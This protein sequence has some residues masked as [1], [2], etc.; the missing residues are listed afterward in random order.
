MV[1]LSCP[2]QMQGTCWDSRL[3]SPFDSLIQQIL[4]ED[5]QSLVKK[6]EQQI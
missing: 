3:G 4:G 6:E 5:G 2:T 1:I